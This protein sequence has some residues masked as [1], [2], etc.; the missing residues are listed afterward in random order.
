MGCQLFF[1]CGYSEC[2]TKYF[3][4]DIILYAKYECRSVGALTGGCCK[5]ENREV[6][7]CEN[8]APGSYIDLL[9]GKGNELHRLYGGF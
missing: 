6:F 5:S 7:N 9:R 4:A 3:K 8:K 2:L 1:L